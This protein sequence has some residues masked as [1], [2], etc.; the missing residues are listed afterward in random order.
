MSVAALRRIGSALRG[1]DLIHERH[2]GVARVQQALHD[3]RELA[4]AAVV[5]F[6]EGAARLQEARCVQDDERGL[7]HGDG[8]RGGGGL[9][10]IEDHDLFLVLLDQAARARNITTSP[11]SRPGSGDRMMA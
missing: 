7:G 8:L 1:G 4:H 10:D 5:L 2:H 6:E 3:E 11:R 9:G